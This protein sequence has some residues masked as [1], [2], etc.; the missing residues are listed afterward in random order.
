ML[1]APRSVD[2]RVGTRYRLP[3]ERPH[4][5]FTLCLAFWSSQ[6][7]GELV[8][9]GITDERSRAQR[10]GSR[11]SHLYDARN[12]RIARCCG[13]RAHRPVRMVHL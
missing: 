11:R 8:E 7:R 4:Q 5:T 13:R 12:L 6:Q 9:V 10:S 2:V 1:K 3:R